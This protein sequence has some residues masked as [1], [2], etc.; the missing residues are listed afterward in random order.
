[1]MKIERFISSKYNRSY[2]FHIVHEWEDEIADMMHLKT[3]RNLLMLRP[4][5]AVWRRIFG[6]I[7]NMPITPHRAVSFVMRPGLLD[8]NIA[9]RNNVVP[10][11]IDFW[12]RDKNELDDFARR[13]TGNPAILVTSKEAYEWIREQCPRLKV[14]H[15][16]LSL[17]DRYYHFDDPEGVHLNWKSKKYDCVMVGRPN[18]KLYEWA[19]RYAESH[20]E[21]SYV[22]NDRKPGTPLNYVSSRGEILG[23]VF[24]TR[25]KYF[26]LLCS[27]R[28]GLYSTPSMDDDK[29]I[30]N[31]FDSRGFNQVTPRFLEYMAAGCHVLSRYEIN[32][33]TLWYDLPNVAPHIETYDD[34]EH[35]MDYAREHEI[36]Y[37]LYRTYLSKHLTSVRVDELKNILEAMS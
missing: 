36:D 9:G 30:Y 14:F 4:I 12:L 1:M 10:I 13:Y 32:P 29:K 27:S 19:K 6:R 28:T 11:L 26:E 23:D 35:R 15:W 5:R 18:S 20:P 37:G 16:A 25:G 2:F 33:D 21:F 8:D 31:N 34:F 7:D 3:S 24:K 22:Y 17:P